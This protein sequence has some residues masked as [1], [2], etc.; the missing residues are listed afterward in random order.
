M[1][2]TELFKLFGAAAILLSP[3]SLPLLAEAL[4]QPSIHLAG[5]V[6]VG[7]RILTQGT[8]EWSYKPLTGGA[9][10]IVRT[11]LRPYLSESGVVE[12][13]YSV[14]VPLERLGNQQGNRLPSVSRGLDVSTKTTDYLRS[15]T[16]DNQPLRIRT[17]T[18]GGRVAISER[19][20]L[21]ALEVVD[22]SLINST[23]CCFGDSN[24]DQ[25]VS[26]QDFLTTTEYFGNSQSILG[27]ANCDAFANV[28]D[29]RTIRSEFGRSCITAQSPSTF[30]RYQTVK[31]IDPRLTKSGAADLNLRQLKSEDD[32]AVVI[33]LE[34]ASELEPVSLGGYFIQYDPNVLTFVNG[35]ISGTFSG[36]FFTGHP[37][38]V[39]SGLIAFPVGSSAGFIGTTEFAQLTF[40]SLQE[41]HTTVGFV[42]GNKTPRTSQVLGM[43]KQDL[44]I[45]TTPLEL[46]LTLPTTSIQDWTLHE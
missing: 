8:L 20:F 13:S 26:I 22:L 43:G 29:Y 27:D 25:V 32:G 42:V 9:P 46:T 30:L 23:D 45:F 19:A 24:Q 3:S 35:S 41:T 17:S 16:L 34:I 38:E 15:A 37:Q 6:Y 40:R 44:Q 2:P 28:T 31:S 33:S 12:Y 7:D 14:V 10:F 18:Y 21:G 36:D 4:P 11:D 5:K 1:K 39:D